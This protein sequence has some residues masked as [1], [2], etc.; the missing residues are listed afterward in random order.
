M[1]MLVLLV[2]GQT[3]LTLECNRGR[4]TPP[5][6]TG[7]VLPVGQPRRVHDRYPMRSLSRQSTQGWMPL[8]TQ[9]S[10][11]GLSDSVRLV[12]QRRL[13]VYHLAV[14][15]A[16]NNSDINLLPRRHHTRCACPRG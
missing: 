12:A 2:E 7:L 11:P 3:A 5:L 1:L 14:S 4:L 10:N 16:T 6:Q 9:V 8:P 13:L 15:T